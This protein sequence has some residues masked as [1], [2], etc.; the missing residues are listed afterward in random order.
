VTIVIEGVVGAAALQAGILAHRQRKM[1]TEAPAWSRRWW[2]WRQRPAAL[3][4]PA[5]FLLGRDRRTPS[6]M[7]GRASRA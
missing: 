1:T 3:E 6:R 5:G 2:G 4:S 7:I